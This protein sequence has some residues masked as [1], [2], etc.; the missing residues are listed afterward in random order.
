M[1]KSLSI[2]IL[3][4][5]VSFAVFGA[6]TMIGMTDHNDNCWAKSANGL[7]CPEGMKPIDEINFHSNAL[8]KFSVAI[9]QNMLLLSL[10]AT[11]LFVINRSSMKDL[12][13]TLGLPA[14]NFRFINDNSKLNRSKFT[15]WL[16]ILENSPSNINTV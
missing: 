15:R 5:F 16:S 2:I 12:F 8:A 14:F 1:K 11:M 9:F 10:F 13:A 4:I 7:I 6:F 3:A